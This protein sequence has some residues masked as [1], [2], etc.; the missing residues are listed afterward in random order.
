MK[1]NSD[2]IWHDV[3]TVK[4]TKNTIYPPGIFRFCLSD[5]IS[6][7]EGFPSMNYQEK[8]DRVARIFNIDYFDSCTVLTDAISLKKLIKSTFSAPSLSDE[9]GFIYIYTF[10]DNVL[11][12]QYKQ[13]MLWWAVR[14]YETKLKVG[15][16]EQNI[17]NRI[18]QQF[19]IRTSISEPPI[20]LTALWTNRV[21][22]CER[23]IHQQLNSKR[24]T[25]TTGKVS[26]GGVEWFKDVPS[27][28]IPIVLHWVSY[29]RRKDLP[30]SAPQVSLVSPS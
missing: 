12:G 24:L 26:R 3:P 27:S 9:S 18:S 14:R 29:Y 23:T 25:D 16:T 22:L 13:G 7:W 8:K 11:A 28:A 4:L 10:E 2:D 15:R 21:V 17:F 30:S 20:L 1:F 5:F 6:L 19:D